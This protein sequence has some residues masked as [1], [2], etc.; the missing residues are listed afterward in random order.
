M[1]DAPRFQS[2]AVAFFVSNAVVGHDALGG[3]PVFCEPFHRI[4]G[5]N[6]RGIAGFVRH[7]L[8]VGHARVVVDGDMQILPSLARSFS[9][10]AVDPVANA[11]DPAKFFDID[12]DDFA[13][14]FALI[15]ARFGLWFEVAF[16]AD[17]VALQGSADGGIG[18]S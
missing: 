12:M 2:V 9:S 10:V 16:A 3:Y 17:A 1:L 8:A 18:Q 5:K 4:A 7:D 15:S 6:E 14:G 13:W 11:I